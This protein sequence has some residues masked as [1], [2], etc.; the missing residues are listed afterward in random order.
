MWLA[1]MTW[2]LQVSYRSNSW[3]PCPIDFA[4]SHDTKSIPAVKQIEPLVSTP[5]VSREPADQMSMCGFTVTQI[6]L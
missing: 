1:D 3:R 5:I 2:D 4:V 6:A